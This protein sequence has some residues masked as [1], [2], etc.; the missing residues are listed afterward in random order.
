MPTSSET[1]AHAVDAVSES[2]FFAR[3]LPR[4]RR[5]ALARRIAD[6]Q[7]LPGSYGGLFAPLPGE[8]TGGITTFTGER[9]TSDAGARHVLGEEAGRA[10]ILLDLPAGRPA[11]A[12]ATASFIG[13]LDESERRGY[14]V[15]TY[16][17]G[18]C[19]CAYWRHLTAGGLDRQEERLNKGLA[20]LTSR[21]LPNGRW[22]AFPFWYTLLALAEIRSPAAREEKRHAAPVCER[23]LR[24]PAAGAF[25]DRRRRVAELIL[26]T[27]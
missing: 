12:K 7:G 9:I 23:Y 18:S 22:R 19:S 17:C 26:E 16:C 6:R 8:L 1:L 25:A 21:R 24:R 10:L 20:L 2:F 27:A 5:T 3:P 4:T 15:G 13:R 11:V 14:G